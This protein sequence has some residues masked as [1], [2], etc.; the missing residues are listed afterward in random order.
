M[1]T[2]PKDVP[3]KRKS[4]LSVQGDLNPGLRSPWNWDKEIPVPHSDFLTQAPRG[5]ASPRHERREIR[6]NSGS[7]AELLRETKLEQETQFNPHTTSSPAPEPEGSNKWRQLTEG[8]GEDN[9][10][11]NLEEYIENPQNPEEQPRQPTGGLPTLLHLIPIYL[12]LSQGR[13][14]NLSGLLSELSGTPITIEM[15]SK[16]LDLE[17]LDP[18]TPHGIR[19]ED[20]I[21]CLTEDPEDN[22]NSFIPTIELHTARLKKAH[23][24]GS[25]TSAII[26]HK[27][28]EGIDLAN[29][30]KFLQAWAPEP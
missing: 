14:D 25:A 17:P 12:Q 2:E 18:A 13:I 4:K 30:G 16:W 22:L 23:L 21:E 29:I 10:T 20:L 15:T 26:Q 24:L 9:L 1:E 8:C 27:W 3:P 5:R 19:T 7:V 6:T 11:T 28:E